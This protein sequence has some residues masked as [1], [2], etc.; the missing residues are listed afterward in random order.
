MN[1]PGIPC[2]QAGTGPTAHSTRTRRLLP[3]VV[4]TRNSGRTARRPAGPVDGEERLGVQDAL[5]P[6]RLLPG[7]GIPRSVHAGFDHAPAV[8]DVG[9]AIRRRRTQAHGGASAFRRRAGWTCWRRSPA[10]R[11]SRRPPRRPGFPPSTR[12]SRPGTRRRRCRPV[13]IRGRQRA[14]PGDHRH[15]HDLAAVRPAGGLCRRHRFACRGA[16]P[17]IGTRH[18]TSVRGDAHQHRS[19]TASPPCWL[20]S[21]FVPHVAA[22][23]AYGLDDLVQRDDRLHRAH[24]VALDAQGSARGRRSGR[25]SGRGCVPCPI[26][27]AFSTCFGVPPITAAVR[28]V[29]AI[30]QA[31]PTSPW[32]PTSA[33]EIEAFSL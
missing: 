8:D 24:R 14:D 13:G 33:P 18:D 10:K 31:T 6:G 21:L 27:A 19:F 26:S 30:E 20:V 3:E 4:V 22:G 28:P 11:R 29:A 5:K 15:R 1:A 25:R 9:Q 17:V 2:A 7:P 32:Q 23:V 16:Q 12:A